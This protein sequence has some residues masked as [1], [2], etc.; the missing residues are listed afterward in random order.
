ARRALAAGTAPAA[1]PTGPVHT[2]LLRLVA[3][4]E[5]GTPRRVAD[6][7]DPLFLP[8]PAAT[9]PHGTLPADTASHHT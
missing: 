1:C 4:I 3:D 7:P 2:A 8:R 9:A 6:E 5:A